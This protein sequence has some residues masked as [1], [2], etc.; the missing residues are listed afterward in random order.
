MKMMKADGL[1][2]RSGATFSRLLSE[3]QSIFVQ[4]YYTD[5]IKRWCS[6]NWLGEPVDKVKPIKSHKLRCICIE[7][8]INIGRSK[9]SANKTQKISNKTIKN[10]FTFKHN[11]KQTEKY[12]YNSFLGRAE[13]RFFVRWVTLSDF[14]SDFDR[15]FNKSDFTKRS[16]RIFDL[17]I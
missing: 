7:V 12:K 3:G 9:L 13:N 8:K 4:T 2:T 16:F 17:F 15:S 5:R 10:L 11:S 1:E 6:L 14:L